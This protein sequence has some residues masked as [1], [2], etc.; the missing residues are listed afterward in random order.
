MD[1]RILYVAFSQIFQIGPFATEEA[2]MDAAK[3]ACSELHGDEW[4][5]SIN[6]QHVYLLSDGATNLQE[7]SAND[8]GVENA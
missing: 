4:E 6:N 7:L 3:A 8:L 2:A 5:F 1:Y